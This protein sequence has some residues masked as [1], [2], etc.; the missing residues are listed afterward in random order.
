MCTSCSEAIFKMFN[1]LA[2]IVGEKGD[3]SAP[4]RKH[5]RRSYLCKIAMSVLNLYPVH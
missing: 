4:Y 3:V 1:T 5:Q 2:F